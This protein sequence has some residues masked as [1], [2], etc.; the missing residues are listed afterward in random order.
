[1]L[2]LSSCANQYY[3]GDLPG[4]IQYNKEREELIS[5]ITEGIDEET[6]GFQICEH[7][8]ENL[9]RITPHTQAKRKW[10]I[11]LMMKLREGDTIWLKAALMD[12]ETGKIALLTSTNSMENLEREGH[13]GLRTLDDSWFVGMYRMCAP[14]AF[15]RELKN[16]LLY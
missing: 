15:W 9:R 16:R 11:L 1:M 2:R 13:R 7:S 8:L 14:I 3:C 5:L 4:T 10:K 6:R 12:T